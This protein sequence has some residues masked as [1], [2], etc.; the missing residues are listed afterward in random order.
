MTNLLKEIS[1]AKE[2]SE[3]SF[4]RIELS[5]NVLHAF[6]KRELNK[7]VLEID[8]NLLKPKFVYIQTNNYILIKV[9]L[10]HNP[11]YRLIKQTDR[12]GRIGLFGF[13]NN[14]RSR[15]VIT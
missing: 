3:N 8:V 5:G 14:Y 2:S 9:G 1:T 15:P 6:S 13:W 4:S 11:F 10:S 12:F 7:E